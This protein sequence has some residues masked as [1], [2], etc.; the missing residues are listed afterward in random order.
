MS[1]RI[2]SVAIEERRYMSNATLILNK[3][4]SVHAAASFDSWS[5]E[6]L[7]PA[8]HQIFQIICKFMWHLLY[9]KPFLSYSK[10]LAQK[11]CRYIFWVEA[12]RTEDLWSCRKWDTHEQLRLKFQMP[13]C[14]LITEISSLILLTGCWSMKLN[15]FKLSQQ[16]RLLWIPWRCRRLRV[17][18]AS[19]QG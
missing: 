13:R 4:Q 6:V 15:A 18:L 5:W 11:K 19:N 16:Q 14:I 7:P 10:N 9:A 17:C 2:I 3:C 12:Y 1:L 8:A